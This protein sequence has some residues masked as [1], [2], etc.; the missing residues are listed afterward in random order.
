SAG[1]I[2][3]TFR[4]GIAWVAAHQREPFFLFLHS[5]EVHS[6]YRPARE[7]RDRFPTPGNADQPRV[8]SDLY[9]GEVAQADVAVGNL[10]DELQRLGV[11]ERTL[12]VVT[13]D[14]GEEFGE[15]G[16]RYHGAHLY[17]EVLH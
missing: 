15:H 10:V 1:T 9:D 17:D 13:S 4:R 14:H 6:P 2:E 16:G 8:D 3:E 5:Y 12:L 7:F 11:L